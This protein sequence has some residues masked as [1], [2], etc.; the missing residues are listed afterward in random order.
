MSSDRH[1]LA[2]KDLCKRLIQICDQIICILNS[3]RKPDELLSDAHFLAVFGGDHRMRGQHGNR[4]QRFDSPKAWCE[5]EQVQR[6]AQTLCI[7][8]R[9]VDF[10]AEHATS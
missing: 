5:S 4:D 3:Y 2:F 9:A 7:F 10:K 6:F 8:T 1:L